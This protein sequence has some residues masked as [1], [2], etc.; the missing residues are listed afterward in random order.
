LI[1]S[2]GTMDMEVIASSA[3]AQIEGSV[4]DSHDQPASNVTVVAIP[5]PSRRGVLDHYATALS[6]QFGRFQLRGLRPDDY[7]VLAWEEVE[8]G[9]WC[10]PDFLQAYENAG[11]K[12]HLDEGGRQNTTVRLIP[13]ADSPEPLPVLQVQYRF[14]QDGQHLPG[15]LRCSLRL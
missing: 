11:Q 1:M 3:S 4:L 5:R 15:G 6:D 7:T 9:A 14:R 2:G 12:I 13:S 8:S 10:D